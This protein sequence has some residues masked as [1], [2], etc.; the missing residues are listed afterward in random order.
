MLPA[1]SQIGSLTFE[2][3]VY[4]QKRENAHELTPDWQVKWMHVRTTNRLDAAQK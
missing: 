3:F 2:W 1:T 4:G